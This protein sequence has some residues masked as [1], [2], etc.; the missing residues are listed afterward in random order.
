LQFDQSK[1]V[2]SNE[3]LAQLSIIIPTYNESQ[4]ILDLLVSIK[5]TLCD[6]FSTEI[7]VVDDN[8]PDNTGRLVE[9][10]SKNYTNSGVLAQQ[11]YD[12]NLDRSYQFS[13][14]S[15]RVIHRPR[16]AGLISA[17]L[18]GIRS[19][20]GQYILVMDADFSHSPEM[21]PKMLHELG[22]SDID[23]VIASRYAKGGSIVGW[24]LKRKVISKG[25]V[26]IAKYVLPISKEVKDPMSGFFALKRPVLRHIAIDSAGYKILLEILVKS[27]DAKVK[28]VPYTF[29]DRK[30]GKSKLDNHV[31]LDYIKSVYYLYLYGRRS[32]KAKAQLKRV[33]RRKSAL[34]LSKAGRFYT[35]GASGLL[36]NYVISIL[37][38]NS[39]DTNLGYLQ[40]TMLGIVASNIS[41]FF[42]NKV[43]TF[44]DRDFSIKRTLRQYGVFAAISSAGIAIQLGSLYLCVE[45]GIQYELSL[46][47][48]VILASF[49]NFLLNK[50][51]TFGEK[52]WG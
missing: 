8:S 4:N 28:E 45:S 27:K 52:V 2:L 33:G 32:A 35:V 22:S 7:I 19:S 46:L 26:K 13:Y 18:E 38:S 15:I 44:E 48:A 10:Y 41:N 23:V 16:K 29:A 12:I 51:F 49:G 37:L 30:A 50:K 14:F 5:K 31:I 40:A 25:A 21:I 11:Q 1:E 17:I 39:S 43:W 36:L 42:L 3:R 20:N 34:F 24:S 6:L 47:T 9:D